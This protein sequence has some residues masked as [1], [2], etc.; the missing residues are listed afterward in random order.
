MIKESLIFIKF[1]QTALFSDTEVV[2]QI[3]VLRLH[4]NYFKTKNS[5]LCFSASQLKQMKHI[6]L[7]LP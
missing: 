2:N 5:E 4:I 3:E 7:F 1:V 6:S